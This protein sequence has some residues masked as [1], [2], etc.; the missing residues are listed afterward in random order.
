MKCSS[1]SFNLN[2]LLYG[3]TGLFYNVIFNKV[4]FNSAEVL[5]L[6]LLIL[7]E[8]VY[9][10]FGSCIETWIVLYKFYRIICFEY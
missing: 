3:E 5:D 6:E 10:K 8:F 7:Q 2:Y 1:F 4:L 9:I